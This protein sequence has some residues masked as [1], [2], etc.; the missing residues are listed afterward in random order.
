MWDGEGES[1][2]TNPK[3]NGDGFYTVKIDGVSGTSKDL[4]DWIG[5]VLAYLI[6]K[7]DNIDAASAEKLLG[8]AIKGGTQDNQF[9]AY[10]DNNT[11]GTDPDNF[12]GGD[13]DGPAIDSNKLD[14]TFLYTDVFA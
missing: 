2:D 9:F 14:T 3:P 12:P 1:P 7:D 13:L 4:D 5:D 10:G 8:V 6:A 11:N